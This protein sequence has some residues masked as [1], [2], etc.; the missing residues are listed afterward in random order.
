MTNYYIDRLEAEFN[1][2]DDELPEFVPVW[3][4]E[5]GNPSPLWTNGEETF[6]A[7]ENE[8]YPGYAIA[9]NIPTS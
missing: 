4:D 6:V 5:D 2:N 3:E 1:Q 9:E 8:E 7:H